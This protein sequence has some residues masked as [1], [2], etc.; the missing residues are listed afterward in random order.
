MMVEDGWMDGAF[1]MEDGD[2]IGLPAVSGT[3]K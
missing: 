3:C 2:E 1:L